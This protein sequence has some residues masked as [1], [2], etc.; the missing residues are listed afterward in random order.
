MLRCGGGR[1]RRGFWYER[2]P[3]SRVAGEMF[4]VCNSGIGFPQ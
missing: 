3:A 4:I 1:L 2:G